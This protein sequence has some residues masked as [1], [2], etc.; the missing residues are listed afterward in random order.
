MELLTGDIYVATEEEHNRTMT[1]YYFNVGWHSV[2]P[3]VPAP[4]SAMVA[5]ATASPTGQRARS[6]LGESYRGH[7]HREKPDFTDEVGHCTQIK[8]AR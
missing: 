7:M 4:S 1:L 6:S 5:C 2:S 3:N 8:Q